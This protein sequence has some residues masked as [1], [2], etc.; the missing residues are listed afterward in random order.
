MASYSSPFYQPYP[1]LPLLPPLHAL[2]PE[3][4]I[5]KPSPRPTVEVLIAEALTGLDFSTPL[6][7]QAPLP[8]LPSILALPSLP[9]SPTA[10]HH[11]SC[12]I[13]SCRIWECSPS[14]VPRPLRRGAAYFRQFRQLGARSLERNS[15]DRA[16]WPEGL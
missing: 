9:L 6:P 10:A 7:V 15:D 5:A 1:A 11:P 13:T 8:S 14:P 4:L 12:S 2:I 16:T 3:H